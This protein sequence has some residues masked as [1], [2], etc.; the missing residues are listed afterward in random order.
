MIFVVGLVI[1]TGSV[2][3]VCHAQTV[4]G[5]LDALIQHSSASVMSGVFRMKT[6]GCEKES[7]NMDF[8][9]H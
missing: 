7:V 6:S 1:S 5:V 9:Q 4:T 3:M 2:E 8:H